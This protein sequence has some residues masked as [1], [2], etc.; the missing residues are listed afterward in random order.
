MPIYTLHGCT[1]E[2]AKGGR[3]A[4]AARVEI[5]DG[6]KVIQNASRHTFYSTPTI[7]A[8]VQAQRWAKALPR[9]LEVVATPAV[10]EAATDEPTE[11]DSDG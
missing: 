10:A 9:L 4:T 2:V 6:D 5:R 7:T 1:I 11:L 8:Q 3:S